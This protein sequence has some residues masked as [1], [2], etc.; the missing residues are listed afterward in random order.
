ML[1]L[2][3][4]LKKSEGGGDP[5]PTPWHQINEMGAFFRRGS[6]GLIAAAPGVGKSVVAQ[7][8]VQNGDG[9]GTTLPALFF[10]A[11]TEATTFFLRAAAITSGTPMSEIEDMMEQSNWSSI[12]ERDVAA[13]TEHIRAVFTSTITQRDLQE[14]VDAYAMV[15][16]AYPKVIVVDNLS[17][18][19]V[20]DTGERENL[21]NASNLL[22]DMAQETNAAVLTLHHVTGIYEDGTTIVP[23]SGLLSK[24]S[25]IPSTIWTLHRGPLGLNVSVVKNRMGEADPGGSLFATMPIDLSRVRIG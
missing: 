1:S 10:S 21:M 4:G 16:G 7:S 19:F 5:I 11:D 13:A 12:I 15:F 18:V 24:V 20:D 22:K 2:L 25:K 8:L 14:E 3:Q 9:N 6:L 23:Q 17:N